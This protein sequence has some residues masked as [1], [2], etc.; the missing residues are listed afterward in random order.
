MKFFNK[1][2]K[3]E[4]GHLLEVA[5]LCAGVMILLFAAVFVSSGG[6]AKINFLLATNHITSGSQ[7]ASVFPEN[8]TSLSGV[9]LYNL[10]NN[11]PPGT[12][13]SWVWIAGTYG[14][15]TFS[16]VCLGSFV[17]NY[18][19]TL[20]TSPPSAWPAPTTNNPDWLV[21]GDGFYGL[22]AYLP[23]GW[24]Y[25]GG[26]VT[27]NAPSA[28][29]TYTYYMCSW[30]IG[31]KYGAAY[32]CASN[33]L[34][35]TPVPTTL[36][37][38]TANP[39][40]L[41]SSNTGTTLS[42]TGTAGTGFTGCTLSGGQ[43]GAGTSVG[44]NSSAG[45]TVPLVA[46]TTYTVTCGDSG[47]GPVSRTIT[48]P[49]GAT[50]TADMSTSANGPVYTASVGAGQNF[51]LYFNAD[52]S[53]QPTQCAVKDST[54]TIV[55]TLNN[56]TPCPASANHTYTTSI[57]TPGTY[58]YTF[59]YFQGS[60]STVVQTVTIT[61][62]PSCSFN[63]T[64]QV[65]SF[66]TPGTTSWY[67]PTGV[68]S[69]QYL[70]V[71]GGGGGAGVWGGGG[72][73][74]GVLT[75]TLAVTPNTAVTVTVGSGG[76]G[77]V[78]ASGSNGNNSVF[79]S[80]TAI[81]GGGGGRANVA[82]SAGGSGG[83]GGYYNGGIATP[84]AGTN[85]Q[86]NAG[87][88]GS[89][90]SA[91]GTGGGGGGAGAVGGNGASV[92]GAGGAGFSSNISGSTVFYG[93]GGGGGYD[94]SPHS[95]GSGGAGG[96]G[97][98][99]GNNGTGGAGT[100]NSGG[101]G[102]G[103]GN[104]GT[105]G[106]GGSG[107]VIVQYTSPLFVNQGSTATLNYT[108][109]GGMSGSIDNGLGA[110]ATNAPVKVYKVGPTSGTW[111]V[112]QGAV[113]TKVEAI[114]GG[115]GGSTSYGGGGGGGAYAGTP[116][117]SSM[118]PGSVLN[119]SVGG[120]GG[121]GAPGGG[122]GAT[123]IQNSL[124]AYAVYAAAGSPGAYSGV[125][126]PVGGGAGGAAA[127]G[128]GTTRNSGGAGGNG[129]A[130]GGGGGGAGGPSGPG[131]PGGFSNG[132]LKNNTGS[133]NGGGGGGGADGGGG[134]G[135]GAY[136]FGGAGG[137]NGGGAGSNSAGSASPTGPG[138]G[139][140]DN[141]FGAPY[142]P[143]GGGGGGSD[144]TYCGS[145]YPCSSPAWG[146]ANGAAGSYGGGGG[147]GGAIGG[148]ASGGPGILVITYTPG[149]NASGSTTTPPIV[150]SPTTFTMTI[151]N[152]ANNTGTTLT[153]MCSIPVAIT[154]VCTN[155]SGFQSTLPANATAVGTTCTCS[156][157]KA[158]D[159]AAC[160]TVT[161]PTINQPSII[162]VIT[163]TL[164]A[165]SRVKKGNSVTLNW[166]VIG[167]T[168][169]DNATSC[170]VSSNPSSAMTI[171]TWNHTGTIW[172]QASNPIS[173]ITIN[174]TTIFTISCTNP[175]WNPATFAASAT[176]GLVPTFQEQ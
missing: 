119:Y 79:G 31:W 66:T 35:V 75:G 49:V 149:L 172:T 102:G 175:A 51:T 85:G 21:N 64:P 78:G 138:G 126:A 33:S 168:N 17:P 8:N 44:I 90:V 155:F 141:A 13:V 30:Y 176:V 3:L 96:G 167:L 118:L 125:G 28:A 124:G 68:T 77:G 114:G 120:G 165:V 76:L 2:K 24:G 115:G 99:V 107:V 163:G 27:I 136:L 34:T 169:G 140:S 153:N 82:G 45:P 7:T 105:G 32:S 80:V 74:G 171:Q 128:V 14:G 170:S 43:Y 53:T 131:G 150:A 134:G 4:H 11:V 143:G 29:G 112:P 42:W 46:A 139:A 101:G 22:G 160:T 38:L 56:T 50:V 111:T 156:V 69:V 158:W 70:V 100:A 86:G 145:G 151:N 47:F 164:T 129:S 108:Q 110:F 130:G 62:L 109:I 154:D 89:T 12:P 146:G 72:G 95:A 23:Q 58:T 73:G 6:I 132:A 166:S 1:L 52:S 133:T 67:P 92:A 116:S 9:G 61:V 48:V 60:W 40:A 55:N 142:G 19:C 16:N 63:V 71:A 18:Q 88:S 135:W 121:G 39:I 127:S 25:P 117:P 36:S 37:S 54:A 59:Q 57:S 84:G 81:G 144:S 20:A 159:G 123:Y 104:P 106:A 26:H 93:G 147:G 103:G 157:G 94:S 87:G 152:N 97:N 5:G 15:N 162:P 10:Q 41:A 122:G 174:S 137:S 161:T 83:G 148:G 173:P 65:V 113:V 91:V 98:G